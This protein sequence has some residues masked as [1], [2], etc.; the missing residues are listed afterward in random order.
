[1][2]SREKCLCHRVIVKEVLI[3]WAHVKGYLSHWQRAF[4]VFIH[5][6]GN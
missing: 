2:S 6:I 4:A 5:N 1:M 3:T